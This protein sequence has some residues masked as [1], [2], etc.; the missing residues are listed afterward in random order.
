MVNIRTASGGRFGA[1][2]TYEGDNEGFGARFTYIINKPK[3]DKSDSA[4]KDKKET[5]PNDSLTVRIYDMAGNEV[6]TMY[7]KTDTAIQRIYWGG[8]TN[9]VRSP[10]SKAP[11]NRVTPPYGVAVLPGKYKVVFTYMETSD[12]AEF[13][14][15]Y[16][17]RV[18]YNMSDL[19]A[20]QALRKELDG[21]V[22]QATLAMDKINEVTD[23]LEIY[24]KIIEGNDKL[25]KDSLEKGTKLVKDS[26]ESIKTYLRG[27][28]GRKGMVSRYNTYNHFMNYAYYYIDAASNG[29]NSTQRTMVDRVKRMSDVLVGKVNHFLDNEWKEYQTTIKNLDLNL[30]KTIEKVK[31]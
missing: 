4:S 10:G 14:M 24:E 30:F 31:E 11:K 7:M 3:E 25:E 21:Y 13:V 5:L 22:S 6:R 19:K 2:A 28:S 23:Q 16:D 17:P 20:L 26:I 9:G 8:E 18:E 12:T 1:D 29:T 15:N 27:A